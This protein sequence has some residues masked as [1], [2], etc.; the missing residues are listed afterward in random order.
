M[1]GTMTETPGSLR[2]SFPFTWVNKLDPLQERII[3][4]DARSSMKLAER[5]TGL[6]DYD[7]EDFG[8]TTGQVRDHFGDYCE[9]F[10]V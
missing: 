4:I 9:R 5:L 6:H 10:G 2:P 1:A 7:I 3:P 8:L